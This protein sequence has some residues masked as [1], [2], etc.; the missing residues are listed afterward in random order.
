MNLGI[1]GLGHVAKYQIGALDELDGLDL[2]ATCDKDVSKKGVYSADFTTDLDEMLSLNLDGVV[3][4]VPNVNHYKVVK[5]VLESGKHTLVEKP[6]TPTLREF[7]ELCK[8]ADENGVAM[9]TAFHAAFAPD[10]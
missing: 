1:V 8:I 10:V 7:D 9:H 2:V 3:V 6:A 5:K 4:S